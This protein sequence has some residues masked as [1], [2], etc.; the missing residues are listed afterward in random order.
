MSAVHV[1]PLASLCRT[2]SSLTGG[3]TPILLSE[4]FK[5]TLHNKQIFSN[6]RWRE[7]CNTQISDDIS[8][9]NLNNQNNA[10]LTQKTSDSD[11]QNSNSSHLQKH[12][13]FSLK[14]DLS[15]LPSI[16]NSIEKKNSHSSNKNY[17][18][19]QK[20]VRQKY[21]NSVSANVNA[22]RLSVSINLDSTLASSSNYS[23]EVNQTQSSNTGNSQNQNQN[24][25][26]TNNMIKTE[27]VEEK[28]PETDREQN[29]FD[30]NLLE[31]CGD[32]E[33]KYQ[34]FQLNP[35]SSFNP[36]NL[37]KKTLKNM[38]RLIKSKYMAYEVPN[39]ALLLKIER[40]E[41]R[42][43][44]IIKKEQEE[45]KNAIRDY[46]KMMEK[47]KIGYDDD[48]VAL[49]G[50]RKARERMHMRYKAQ[51]WMKE[52]EL[53]YL[54]EGQS[55]SIDAIRLKENLPLHKPKLLFSDSQETP[56]IYTSNFEKK[57]KKDIKNSRN[58]KYQNTNTK[59][60]QKEIDFNG[61]ENFHSVRV[62][63][64]KSKLP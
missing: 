46:K 51:M 5:R 22:P 63:S 3:P 43:R 62:S 61:T 58:S 8:N 20:N 4:R 54:V 38:P 26:N 29:S 53:Q 13:D 60:F 39:P 32:E 40:S 12:N 19:L 2:D 1:E 44:I 35:K 14:A 27:I 10:D 41:L 7:R 48:L 6:G 33:F 47:K 11:L 28:F 42:S 21:S 9:S 30:D 36:V 50:A 18:H 24:T 45:I 34:P 17:T 37:T 52:L 16:P 56:S 23:A 64:K 59:S 25:S 49:Q 31:G 15:R 57:K 55:N